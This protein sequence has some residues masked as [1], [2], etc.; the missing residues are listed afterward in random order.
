M[1][2]IR[3]R[4]TTSATRR[5]IRSRTAAKRISA[6]PRTLPPYDHDR[7]EECFNALDQHIRANLQ[8]VAPTNRVSITL[9]PVREF[10]HTGVVT[11][12]R[13][14]GSARWI[15]GVRSDLAEHEV[16]TG[17]PRL[18]KVCSA[19]HI[20]RLVQEALPG[21]TIE[22]LGTPPAAASPKVGMQYF[23][24]GRSGPCWETTVQTSEVG[25]YVPAPLSGAQLELVVVLE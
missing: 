24:I 22:H 9:Q 5:P 11:D 17:V 10:L 12:S 4:S 1:S 8:I 18:V 16:V 15:L 21:L 20:L 7:L 6:H 25:V 13:C 2:C 23:E 14:F 3:Y 19:R